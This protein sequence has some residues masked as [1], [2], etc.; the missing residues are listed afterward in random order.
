MQRLHRA[1]ALLAP[2]ALLTLAACKALHPAPAEPARSAVARSE[3]VPESRTPAAPAPAHEPTQANQA[4]IAKADERAPEGNASATPKIAPREAAPAKPPAPKAAEPRR[5]EPARA[6]PA[7]EKPPVAPS[8]EPAAAPQPRP[9]SAPTKPQPPTLDVK[10]LEQRLKDTDAIGVMTK[11]ALKNQ[12]DDLLDEFREY[13]AGRSRM[14][15]AE[16]RRPFDLLLM[17]VLSLLQDRDPALARTINQS[18]EA[19]W[20][21]LADRTQF[22]KLS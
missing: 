16:L 10:A 22:E 11:L 3:P 7:T 18:R 21:I 12:V 9:A 13:Y 15:L 20:A 6:P 19:L 5:I 2:V 17:K 8:R 4:P 1:A 14:T